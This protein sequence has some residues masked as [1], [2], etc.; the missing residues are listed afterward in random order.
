MLEPSVR[1]RSLYSYA[2]PHI[3]HPCP[4]GLS[5]KVRESLPSHILLLCLL[6]GVVFS[7]KRSRASLG[8]LWMR[9]R[10]SANA[11]LCVGSRDSPLSLNVRVVFSNSQ[12]VVDEKADTGLILC[13]LR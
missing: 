9:Q 2:C 11:L 6:P 12:K 3:Q 10:R 1:L 5:C 4:L 13:L 7:E 8:S